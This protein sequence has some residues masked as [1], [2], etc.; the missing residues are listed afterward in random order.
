MKSVLAGCGKAAAVHAAVVSRMEGCQ[1]AGF[2]DIKKERAEQFAAQYGGRAYSSLEELLEQEQAEVL[3]I[4]TPHYLHAAMAVYALNRGVNVF[5]EKPP[6]ISKEQLEMLC[7]VKSDKKLGFCFQN[8]YNPGIQ[9]AKQ[10]LESGEAG[11]A[12]GAR[13]FVTWCRTPEYYLESGW[14]GRMD[15]EGGGALIN[16]SI[17]TMDLLVYL[18]GR[19]I[20]VDASMRNHHLK[21]V[22]DVE[23]TVEAY[24]RFQDS[25]ACFYATTA[26]CLNSPPFIEIICEKM[27]IRIEEM[28]VTIC[29]EDGTVKRPVF[30]RQEALGKSYWGTGHKDCITDFYQALAEERR[31]CLELPQVLSTIN[32]VLATYQS[33]GS[34]ERVSINYK[35]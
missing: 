28:D 35:I 11:K 22:I 26:F 17:H 6:V 14:R 5:M 24:I 33:A 15:T 12:L 8:R 2:A 20:E 13:A 34:G 16:Q 1:W 32:L 4:C 21:G 29:R 30:P 7:S 23:D 27:S 19:P 25:A 9:F 3:H 10:L 31:F 18:L